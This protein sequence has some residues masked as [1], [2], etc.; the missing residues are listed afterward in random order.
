MAQ[1]FH[2]V[3]QLIDVGAESA[4]LGRVARRERQLDRAG[5]GFVHA[6]VEHFE[7]PPGVLR[8]LGEPL[9]GGELRLHG[10]DRAVVRLGGAGRLGSGPADLVELVRHFLQV[11][12]LHAV[13]ERVAVAGDAPALLH[14]RVD[15]CTDLHE[16]IADR[17]AA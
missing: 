17:T 11:Q 13:V 10:F 5:D 4:E 14:R 9:P 7:A 8:D 3:D 6:G 1:R 2:V 16:T 12:R 15:P